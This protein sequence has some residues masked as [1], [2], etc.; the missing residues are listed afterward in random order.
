MKYVVFGDNHDDADTLQRIPMANAVYLHLGDLCQGDPESARKSIKMVREMGALCVS[1]AHDRLAVDDDARNKYKKL[2][3][4][5]KTLGN[6][7]SEKLF[8][9]FYSEGCRLRDSLEDEYL[10]FLAN[11]PE[12]IEMKSDGI[13]IKAVHDTLVDA[14][15]KRI[16]TADSAKANFEADDFD[17]LFLG[18]THTP[19]MY[20]CLGEE[21]EVREKF[22]KLGDRCAK[23]CPGSRFI[24][25][26]GSISVTRGYP[27][28]N[29]K[30]M[31]FE[32]EIQATPSA[33]A[34]GI[35]KFR[36][37]SYGVFDT[38]KGTFEIVFFKN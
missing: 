15:N 8:F 32:D 12:A 2:S 16:L 1:G 21:A 27:L 17:I 37:G 35:F 24:L 7:K 30:T 11:L 3:E 9:K 18:H 22:F 6:K 10:D 20:E 14:S 29:K 38:V 33:F 23:T 5:M 25:N 34:Q 13:K 36:Y 31:L 28:I 4:K 26:P 19:S